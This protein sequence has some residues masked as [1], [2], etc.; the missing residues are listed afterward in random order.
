MLPKAHN[1][2]GQSIT[3]GSHDVNGDGW[4][5]CRFA[6]NHTN[7]AGSYIS[8]NHDGTLASLE[9]IQDPVTLVLLLVTV[10]R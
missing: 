3:S 10:D 4:G 9:L 5:V 7:T 6:I 8:S 2:S 1:N